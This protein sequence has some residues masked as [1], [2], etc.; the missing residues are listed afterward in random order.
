MRDIFNV[1]R[2]TFNDAGQDYITADFPEINSAAF[3]AE[4]NDVETALD[5]QLPF[6]TSSA[7]AQRIANLRCFVGVNRFHSL[8]TLACLPLTFKLATSSR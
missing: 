3:L 7:T 6:T 2:G 1:V 4:D 8:P 5:L